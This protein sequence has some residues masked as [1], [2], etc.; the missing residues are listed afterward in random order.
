MVALTDLD[1]PGFDHGSGFAVNR[2]GAGE[3]VIPSGGVE[4]SYRGP[5]PP[6]GVTHR[7]EI[8]VEARNSANKTIAIGKMA[9]PFPPEGE[10]E[11]RWSPCE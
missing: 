8:R 4:G 2:K 7:Y 10:E 1:Y 5:S 9:F 6:C 11:V 3:A